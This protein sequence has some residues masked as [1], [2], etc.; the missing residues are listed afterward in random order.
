[1]P[2]IE[3]TLNGTKVAADTGMTILDLAKKHG[4]EI[5]TLCH[6]EE[7]KP[8][9]SCWVCAVEVKGRRGFVTSCGTYLSDGMEINTD[10]EEIRQARKMA[11][12]L[13]VSDHYADCE[14]PCKIAC[15]DHVDV[16]GYVSLIANGQ[17]HEAV[18]VIKDTLPM[19]LSIG[20]VCPA[21]CEKECRRQL[22]ED[23]IA[24][25]QLKRYAADE[26]LNDYWTY[27]PEKMP[28][29]GKKIAIIGAGPSGLTCGYYLSNNGYAVDVFEASP[30]A[31]GWLRYGIPE[32][33]LPKAILDKEIAL[34]CSNGMQIFTDKSMGRDVFLNK[35]SQDYDAV[36]VAIGA[37]KAVPMPVKGS[38]L[39]GCYLGVDFLKAYALGNT[40]KLG[41]KVAIVGGGNTAIDCARTSVRLGAQVSIIY[42]RTRDEM[43]AETFEID[44][45]EHEG[46]TFYMLSNPV[47]YMGAGGNLKEVKIEKMK[48][49][50]A[51]SSGRR[52][53]EPTGEYFTEQF[54]NIIAAISQVPDTDALA[55][56]EN[57]VEGTIF[58]I[59]RWSTAIVNED[60]MY[61]GLKNVF[62]GGD[63]RRGAATAIAAIADGRLA[64]EMIGKY[65]EG[66]ELTPPK[67]RF[68]SKKGHKVK[69]ISKQEYEKFDVRQRVPMPEIEVKEASSSFQEVET[70]FPCEAAK[71]EA[72]RCLECGCQVNENCF[73]RKY[74]TDYEVD[75]VR[76]LG[77]RNSHPIDTTHPYILRDANKCINCGRCIRTCAEVQGAAVLGYIYRGFPTLVAPEF[78]QSLTETSCESCG[79]CINV[80]PVGALVDR[81]LYYKMNPLAKQVTIQSCGMCGTGCTIKVEAETCKVTRITTPDSIDKPVINNSFNGRNLCFKGRFGWQSLLA[82]DRLT[83]PQLR[84]G[85][86][87]KTISWTEAGKL[88]SEK[89]SA[90]K[91]PR[92]EVTPFATLEEMLLLQLIAANTG[93]AISSNGYLELFSDSLWTT[94]PTDKPYFQLKKYDT[95]VVIGK[96]SHTLRTMIRLHQRQGRKLILVNPPES[97]F[98]SFADAI[99]SSVES[100]G[101]DMRTLFIYNI[102]HTSEADAFAIWQKAAQVNI[103]T[104]NVLMTSDYPNLTGM[105]ALGIKPVDGKADFILSYGTYPEHQDD[106]AF[107]VAVLP[108]FEE[109]APVDLLL[110]QPT[111]LE[112]EGTAMANAGIVT[113]YSNPAKSSLFNQ[114]LKLCYEINWISPN[115]AEPVYWQQ[116]AFQFLQN[117]EMLNQPATLSRDSLKLQFAVNTRLTKLF[118]IRNQKQAGFPRSV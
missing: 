78:G 115:L 35:L 8:Y 110:P 77:S 71:T 92:L 13:L 16:Q 64:A 39:N 62:A 4:I 23:P 98:N 38:D 19:P 99:V 66:Q 72:E 101:A 7:L 89:F 87:W 31:G 54:D 58:P 74:A 5:P 33:R 105:L 18:K 61:T 32:Y 80:C 25:R 15:P 44:A 14:A 82:E 90:G 93:A 67:G 103:D 42:R 26:D 73:L 106:K 60:N 47:E 70:G 10:S 118:E 117:A 45:A 88:I 20:R 53:P 40:P 17:Y 76:F 114:W 104:S 112:I 21:F 69:E 36:Y 28:E 102:N 41:K 29:K 68:D 37:Q 96:I 27:V 11:L 107:Q 59:S 65:L 111:Y 85:K 52:R 34:M 1:M 95:Y 57:Q 9:G 6:D 108:F 116:K 30:A 84:T 94:Y 100:A 49:G 2:N 43:P 55:Q 79:K 46:V 109:N 3:V 91:K 22:V 83:E 51:D 56:P 63:F 24:I 48:L 86:G 75:P 113:H 81:N 97:K 50:E 12:E